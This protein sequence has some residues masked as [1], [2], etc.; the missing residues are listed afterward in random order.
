MSGARPRVLVI[1]EAANPEWVSVPLVGWSLSHALREVAEVHIVTQIRNREAILRAGLVEGRDF[2]AIDS[3][4]VAAHL[5]RAAEFLRMG[6]GR[7][8]T[9]I[10]A[11][12]SLGY[13]YFERLLWK[14]FGARIA[15]GEWDIVHRVTPLTHTAV[16]PIA[17]RLAR[18]GVPFILGPLNGGVPWPAAFRGVRRQEREFL[19]YFRGAYRALPGWRGTLRAAAAVIAGSHHTASELP[20]W[21]R[22][23]VVWI[24]E[25][26]VDPARFDRA[27]EAGPDGP[28]EA[29][30]IGRLVPYKGPDIA[31]EAS[32][33]FLRDGRMTLDI[34]GDGPM[35]DDLAGLVRRLGVDGAVRFH[36]HL[37]HRKVQDVASRS[38]VMVF[39]SIREFG[40]GVVLEAMAMGIVPLIVDYGGPAEMVT[41]RTALTVP[42][43]SRE[44]IVNSVASHLDRITSDPA[45]LEPMAAAARERV[46]THFTWAAKARQ[47]RDVYDWVLDGRR[48]PP[49]RIL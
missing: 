31:I 4:A 8:W 43:S 23:R 16:S 3:E 27:A 42:M 33:R 26:A 41:P 37:P 49:P 48:G 18:T 10:T 29:V 40:G 25:N 7:G 1:A 22:D 13:P 14:E 11:L 36:G 5:Y 46:L 28:L 15:A 6:E 39:P 30:F 19:S 20:A 47:V 21:V 17:S 34:I 12:A 32:A 38:Q 45:M 24:P 9:V 35:R 2:T 44:D